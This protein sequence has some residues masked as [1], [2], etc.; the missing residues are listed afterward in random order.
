MTRRAPTRLEMQERTMFDTLTNEQR[1]TLEMVLHHYRDD[2][3]VDCLRDL[4][5]P[6]AAHRKRLHR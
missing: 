1:S 6:Q 4:L 2:K 5:R 3:R